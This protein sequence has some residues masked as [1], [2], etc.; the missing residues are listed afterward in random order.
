[1]IFQIY[2]LPHEKSNVKPFNLTPGSMI[3]CPI[4]RDGYEISFTSIIL[5]IQHIV[6][7]KIGVI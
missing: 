4:T 6:H 3:K 2:S 5:L 7:S 1:M